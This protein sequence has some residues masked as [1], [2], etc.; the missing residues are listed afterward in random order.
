MFKLESSQ[1]ELMTYSYKQQCLKSASK[2][3]DQSK[4]FCVKL[5]FS[6]LRELLS[7]CCENL[8]GAFLIVC[9]T[10]CEVLLLFDPPLALLSKIVGICWFLFRT[11][12]KRKDRESGLNRLM[13]ELRR[14][15]LLVLP[16]FS[17]SLFSKRF[18]TSLSS[19][20]ISSLDLGTFEGVPPRSGE[21]P[22]GIPRRSRTPFAAFAE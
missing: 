6:S 8:C 12:P 3:L 17:E 10:L 15:P 7:F 18:D 4:I 11:E 9:N 22:S 13:I 1:L 21:E 20:I 5:E 19:N 16:R 2:V 14:P